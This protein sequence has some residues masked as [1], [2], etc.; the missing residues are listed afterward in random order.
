MTH[1]EIGTDHD[2]EQWKAAGGN[3]QSLTFYFTALNKIAAMPMIRELAEW[4]TKKNKEDGKPSDV[5]YKEA[6]IHDYGCGQGDGT[7]LLQVMFPLSEVV[8]I[9]ASPEAI[10][11]AKQ[12]WPTLRFRL[13]DIREPDERV[14]II[15]TSH[16]LE[17]FKDPG[18]IIGKLRDMC[19]ILIAIVPPIQPDKDGGHKGAAI[20]EEWM[21]KVLMK[22]DGLKMSFMTVRRA[23]DK[24]VPEG[25]ILLLMQGALYGQM[26]T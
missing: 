23:D 9:D 26:I 7:A 6:K 10:A 2:P 5:W 14:H 18:A 24:A 16:T 8:G 20:T 13:G 17:H 4:H 3:L 11:V 22:Y 21:P 12:R 1:A 19:Q 15:Y 25:S